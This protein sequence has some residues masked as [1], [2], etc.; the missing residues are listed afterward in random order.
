M[1][2]AR[3]TAQVLYRVTPQISRAQ[4]LW[5]PRSCRCRCVDVHDAVVLAELLQSRGARRV[6]LSRDADSTGRDQDG[7][8]QRRTLDPTGL[9]TRLR[10]RAVALGAELTQA[11]RASERH[12][13]R[14]AE[15]GFLVVPFGDNR[16]PPRL[17]QIPDPPLVLWVTGAR[18]DLGSVAVALVGSRAG[19]PYACAVAEWLA[20]D[21][22]NRGVT[23]V[24]GLARGVDGAAHKGGLEGRGGTVGVLGCG[25]DVVYPP[26][27]RRLIS[28]VKS[29]GAVITEF[30]PS[31]PPHRFNFPR[32]NRIISGLSAAV[33]VVEANDRSGSLMT[34]RC[35]AEQG[36]EVMAVPGSVLARR[37]RG[38]HALI[39][40]GAKV[41]ETAD[42]ILEEIGEI[43][44][45]RQCAV[46]GPTESSEAST[47]AT[48]CSDR[49]MPARA[50]SLTPWPPSRVSTPPSSSRNSLISS[51]GA[52]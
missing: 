30:G 45:C 1:F 14:S 19:S 31:V 26:E 6:L 12:L 5:R 39:R 41:V 51:S 10:E 32:R 11:H 9:A 36:R 13:R 2:G 50:T 20:S 49:W 48:R 4:I 33:V 52:W 18:P 42:D 21:L 3:G 28:D 40:D 35:A 27:H 38:G 23:V 8:D 7:M 25:L 22:S 46:T 43:D 37:N 44:G 34:A 16:Y 47:G 15:E 29:R 24:S 17:A